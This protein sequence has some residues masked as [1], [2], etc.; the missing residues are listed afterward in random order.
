MPRDEAATTAAAAVTPVASRAAALLL[1]TMPALLP[2]LIANWAASASSLSAT[3]E[4]EGR[5][6]GVA[7]QQAW[8]RTACLQRGR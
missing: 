1:L 2:S 3:S 4:K 7:C 8:G 5:C 6:R